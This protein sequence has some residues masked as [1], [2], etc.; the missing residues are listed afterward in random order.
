MMGYS[1]TSFTKMPKGGMGYKSM[2]KLD[3]YPVT[4]LYDGGKDM[5]V[6]VSVSGSA[7]GDVVRAYKETL[8]VDTPFGKG[9]EGI[10][11][12]SALILLL[13]RI[14]DVGQ[15]SRVDLAVDD[16]GSNYYTVDDV[17]SV[18]QDGHC[19]SKFRRWRNLSESYIDGCK[20]GHTVYLGSRRSDIMLRVYDKGLERGITKPWVRWELEL[21]DSRACTAVRC[22]LNTG[23]I[24]TVCVGILSNYFRV[25]VLDDC[26]KSRCSTDAVWSAFVGGIA[27]LQLYV[28]SIPK[29]LDD[30][31]AWFK[32]QVAPTLAGIIVADGGALDIVVN[33]FEDYLGHMS[34]DMIDI[35]NQVNPG[36]M[37]CR[38]V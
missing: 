30:K 37:D 31:K 5:G 32:R 18:L 34:R 2:L 1:L 7:I 27:R 17:V 24:G 19:V 12:A 36:W 38:E 23:N 14:D 13:R 20:V 10:C 21:K 15:F 35:V 3:G 6:H 4:V 16:I 8:A 25:I 29:T 33:H 28:P 22:L 9:Y 26:N 11:E